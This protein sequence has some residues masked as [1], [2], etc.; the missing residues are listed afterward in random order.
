MNE[1]ILYFFVGIIFFI[2]AFVIFRECDF[3]IGCAVIGILLCT[4]F[5]YTIGYIIG[6]YL[7]LKEAVEKSEL[8]PLDTAS[9]YVSI[10]ATEEGYVFKY[11]SDS[12]KGRHIEEIS[13]NNIYF[14][15]LEDDTIPVIQ[16]H[17]Y[18]FK[19]EWYNLFAVCPDESYIEFIIPEGMITE[20]YNIALQ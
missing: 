8:Y 19:E 1:L 16:K 17:T 10:I 15:D 20:E 18:E 2:I 12:D 9:N 3:A 4:L 14:S 11:I 6:D 7:P 13:G 5:R